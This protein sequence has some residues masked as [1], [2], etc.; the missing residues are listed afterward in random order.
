MIID[1]QKALLKRGEKHLI[2]LRS[3]SAPC[4]PE[5]WD[6]PGG[7]LEEGESPHAGIEREIMEETGLTAKALDVAGTYE[8]DLDHAGAPTHRITIYN[9]ESYFG[10]VRIS[11]EHTAYG[12]KTRDEILNLDKLEPY[13]IK[14]FEDRTE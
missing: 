2:L 1:V 10:E 6:F 9:T 3:P 11:E 13:I 12:W 5:H 4:F 8:L 14:Y 7:K